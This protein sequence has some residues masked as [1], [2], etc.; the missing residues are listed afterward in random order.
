[1]MGSRDEGFVSLRIKARRHEK[2]LFALLPVHVPSGAAQEGG[3]APTEHDPL[4]FRFR[5]DMSVVVRSAVGELDRVAVH[6]AKNPTEERPPQYACIVLRRHGFRA[7]HVDG[8]TVNPTAA[9]AEVDASLRELAPPR[10]DESAPP[11]SDEVT[12]H[13]TEPDPEH[14]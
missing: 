7:L 12:A 13:R 8:D 9:P 6:A 2:V 10:R 1:M 14:V 5:S 11:P 3:P 4:S